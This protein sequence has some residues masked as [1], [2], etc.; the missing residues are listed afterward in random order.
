MRVV[1]LFAFLLLAGPLSALTPNLPAGTLLPGMLVQTR[2]GPMDCIL[3]APVPRVPSSFSHH[4]QRMRGVYAADLSVSTG[5]PYSVRVLESSG[6]SFLDNVAQ[7]T[8]RRWR[9]K[10]RTIYKLVVPIEFRGSS[11]I[12]GAPR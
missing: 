5:W 8:L 7:E 9:F 3:S 1:C 6:D 2:F 10:P 11:V 4:G 12:L